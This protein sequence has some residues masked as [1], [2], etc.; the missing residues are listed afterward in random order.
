MVLSDPQVES[1]KNW[2]A[3]SASGERIYVTFNAR[4]PLVAYST[5]RGA[6]FTPPAPLRE[7]DD[8]H[9]FYAGGAA[10]L[11]DGSIHFAYGAPLNG[12]DDGDPDG[13]NATI[14]STSSSSER[15]RRQIQQPHAAGTFGGANLPYE[16]ST[17]FEV[18]SSYDGGA[19]WST[20]TVDWCQFTQV[21][22]DSAEC[23]SPEEFLDGQMGMAKDAADVLYVLY[24]CNYDL[25]KPARILF[26]KTIAP[27]NWTVGVDVSDAPTD[28][29][30]FHDLPTIAAGNASDV[31][32]M[33]MDNRTGSWNVY[34]RES[35]DGGSTWT[36]SIGS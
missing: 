14:S 24:Q 30:V 22:P 11:S 36:P 2:I 21:C 32:I 33:W 31:R 4:Y 35:T 20:A 34:Y 28:K 26:A 10:V 12:E 29:N 15:R 18:Y 7:P 5:D 25:S 19:T 1:D 13:D 8:V 23:G 9:Y 16:N 3:T 27:G 17:I 6:T